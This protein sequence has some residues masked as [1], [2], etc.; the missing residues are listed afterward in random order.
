MN[1]TSIVYIQPT[2]G[3]QRRLCRRRNHG[4][5]SITHR[6]PYARPQHMYIP[7]LPCHIPVSRNTMNRFRYTLP[8]RLPPSGIY[9]YSR[10]Q[11]PREI[12]H[13]FQN[14]VTDLLR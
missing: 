8:L 10:N 3:Y 2:A 5:R 11:L 7:V 9:T 13:R 4:V 14:S 12:C 1:T 6:M